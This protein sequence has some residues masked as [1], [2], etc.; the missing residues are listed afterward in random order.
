MEFVSC[1]GIQ[2][3]VLSAHMSQDNLIKM[4]CTT[5]E[6]KHVNYHTFKNKKKIKE[7][8]VLSK[9]CNYEKKHTDHKETK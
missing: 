5:P 1:Q 6:C 8:L 2:T 4:E 7:R 3:P 9:Y